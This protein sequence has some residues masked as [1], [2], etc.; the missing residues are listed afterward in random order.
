MKTSQI[1]QAV[2]LRN[3][4]RHLRTMDS[5]VECF[6]RLDGHLVLGSER[7][8]MTPSEVD[9]VLARRLQQISDTAAELDLEI[10]E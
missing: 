2:Q 7:L 9:A 3:D 6:P 10:D 5:K 8:L 4:F 1:G